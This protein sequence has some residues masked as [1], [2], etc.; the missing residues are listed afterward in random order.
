MG[1]LGGSSG[2]TN[3]SVNQ[4]IS[5]ENVRVI[6]SSTL[7]ASRALWIHGQN[8][9]FTFTNCTFTSKKDL[10]TLPGT[11][12]D[13]KGLSTSENGPFPAIINF[14]TCIIED[15]NLG[16]LIDNAQNINF[17]GCWF[18]NLNSA[19]KSTNESLGINISKSRFLNASTMGN[20]II[21]IEGNSIG[22]FTDNLS[23]STIF[24]YARNVSSTLY[25]QRTIFD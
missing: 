9:Q 7:A 25:N 21:D 16:V 2:T 4:F 6:K 24:P 20:Y 5:M 10:S 11:N 14:D 1:F 17:N 22:T 15:A 18:E 23:R 13:I 8:G 3:P 12:I 19:I